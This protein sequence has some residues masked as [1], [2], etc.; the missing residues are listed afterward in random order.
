MQI[1]GLNKERA[2]D[3][4]LTITAAIT[5]ATA[6]KN[7]VWIDI[8]P[9]GLGGVT[10]SQGVPHAFAE[11]S[12]NGATKDV[13]FVPRVSPI[14]LVVVGILGFAAACGTCV[15]WGGKAIPA[16]AYRWNGSSTFQ[17]T[18]ADTFCMTSACTGWKNL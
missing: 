8:S 15:T 13:S 5:G 7:I 6:P 18:D 4:W 11:Y 17:G 12:W 1:L 2:H 10:D 16:G 14:D 3:D 9:D